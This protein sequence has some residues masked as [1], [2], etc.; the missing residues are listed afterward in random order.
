MSNDSDAAAGAIGAAARAGRLRTP[1]GRTPGALGG[2]TLVLI[3]GLQRREIGAGEQALQ[4]CE[5][6]ADAGLNSNFEGLIVEPLGRDHL[7]SRQV[8]TSE[9]AN[10]R[11]GMNS[12]RR[13]K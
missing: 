13:T 10:F 7:H 12:G 6:I 1:V 11:S 5:D 4:F 8:Q 2:E 3:K 9:I